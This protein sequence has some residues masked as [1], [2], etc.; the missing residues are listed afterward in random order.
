[1][2][3]Q[4]FQNGEYARKD[5]LL[6]YRLMENK[7]ISEYT[8]NNLGFRGRDF[9]AA[10]PAGTIRVICVGGSTTIGSNAGNDSF[11]YPFILEELLRQA[12][13]G[14]NKIEVI[15]AGVFGYHSWHSMLRVDNEFDRYDPDVYVFMDGLNDVMAAYGMEKKQLERLA[16][17]VSGSGLLTQLVNKTQES[18]VLRM[19][20]FARG[21]A[22]Y[23]VM[24]RAL[25]A[26]RSRLGTQ[27]F[28]GEMAEKMQLFGYKRNVERAISHVLARNKG[29]ILLNYPWI[30][31]G[32]LQ[33]RE[34]SCLLPYKVD[35][36]MIKVYNFGRAYL[37]QTNADIAKELGVPYVDLQDIF[38]RQ[39]QEWGASRLYSDNM[40]FT[41]YGNY[42]LATAVSRE[43]GVVPAFTSLA[44][45]ETHGDDWDA[46]F[47][48]L[49]S[50]RPQQ[51]D[52]ACFER[53]ML[54]W[55]GGCS[56]EDNIRVSGLDENESDT[57][58]EWRWAYGGKMTF[59]FREAAKR[60]V[61][62]EFTVCNPI[63]SQEMVVLANGQEIFRARNL[64]VQKWLEKNNEG[65][66][67]L[68]TAEGENRVEF[69][70]AKGNHQGFEF[71]PGD[72][73]DLNAAF[74][75]L[76]LIKP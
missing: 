46:L 15:N 2:D 9:T 37:K 17:T 16:N 8:F 23:Q 63:P 69:I 4:K 29:V 3:L 11:T 74:L 48:D 52:I 39:I 31:D 66:F 14:A 42:V 27:D 26:L 47:P 70:F 12:F 71:A 68:T 59:S 51:A 35:P 19:R 30:V 34:E 67:E 57:Q 21:S 41:R 33:G 32:R 72:K 61:R 45:P 54:T 53:D 18:L 64:P 50:W 6:G 38:D 43:L 56:P 13:P 22:L 60:R 49:A 24:E 55:S 73:R 36:D 5:D 10:K 44:G 20:D 75:H 65:T 7:K 28:S 1:M 76:V 62:V 25:N 40:H 58:G